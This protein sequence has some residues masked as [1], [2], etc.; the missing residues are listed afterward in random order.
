M[1]GSPASPRV[2]ALLALA[3]LAAPLFAL[4]QPRPRF[5]NA[6]GLL[7][8][9]LRAQ[10]AP[11]PAEDDPRVRAWLSQAIREPESARAEETAER[12]FRQLAATLGAGN[13]ALAAR[14]LQ[15]VRAR[16]RCQEDGACA[17]FGQAPNPAAAAFDALLELR[18]SGR[19]EQA[20]GDGEHARA[21]VEAAHYA[22]DVAAA[23][24]EAVGRIALHDLHDAE[25]ARPYLERARDTLRALQGEARA[26]PGAKSGVTGYPELDAPVALRLA[27]VWR[28]L[29]LVELERGRAQNA[30]GAAAQ[31]RALLPATQAVADAEPDLQALLE[32]AAIEQRLS[33]C[34]DAL[35]LWERAVRATAHSQ[36]AERTLALLGYASAQ[37][38]CSAGA[39]CEADG[40]GARASY[41]AASEAHEQLLGENGGESY[42]TAAAGLSD[43]RA[44]GLI[45]LALACPGSL[46]LRELALRAA[47]ARK[48]ALLTLALGAAERAPSEFAGLREELRD[49]YAQ[50]A[51]YG[52][53]AIESGSAPDPMLFEH[54]RRAAALERRRNALNPAGAVTTAALPAALRAALPAAQALLEY[55]R[56]VPQDWDGGAGRPARYALFVLQAQGELTLLDLG[57]AA[58]IEALAQ[59][60]L[61]AIER[62][63]LA[64]A[65]GVRLRPPSPR[66]SDQGAGRSLFTRVLAPALGA[67]HGQR[68]LHVVPDGALWLLPFVALENEHGVL[69]D[70]G[71]V[72][73]E[74]VS[75]RELLRAVA[76]APARGLL[77]LASSSYG[78][79]AN[80]PLRSFEALEQTA[81]EVNDVAALWQ[82]ASVE[83]LLHEHASKA[84]LTQRAAPSVL[85]IASHAWVLPSPEPSRAIETWG[86]AQRPPLM[87]PLLRAGIALEGA[88]RSG[89]AGH[90]TALEA[91]ALALHGTQLVLLSACD[92]GRGEIALG[93]GVQGLHLAFLAAGAESVVSSLWA[94]DDATTRQLM[95]AYYSHLLHGEDRVLALHAAMRELRAL[96]SA[97][98]PFFWAPFVLV[99]LGGPLR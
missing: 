7:Q 20:I 55:V 13:P 98:A 71:F 69:L 42:A 52:L 56:Y 26:K 88:N 49:E 65:R 89:T 66:S 47:L 72:I 4:A 46:A 27:S 86:A 90:L 78:P 35:S 61:A 23:F 59:R 76:I 53:P 97:R 50:I 63:A 38:S 9:R 6:A 33:H 24:D 83:L 87:P 93:E 67:L 32:Q 34:D 54:Q 82:P 39:R 80:G 48:G 57:P 21:M 31:A 64:S 92:T 79:V 18:R 70:Q 12:A 51:R 8:G 3:L 44:F 1:S 17:S 30:A 73:H 62:V 36:S 11:R 81:A 68:Y 95:R 75:S 29:A 99:G 15:Y 96:R 16:Q 10:P 58:T 77:A 84:E 74:H 19:F 5:P 14:R 37:A 41:Q 45:S 25:R 2:F 94:V 40:G 43:R 28:A 91:S 60:Q 85:H 22:R